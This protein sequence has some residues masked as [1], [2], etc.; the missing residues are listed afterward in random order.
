[1]IKSVIFGT[2]L[3]PVLATAGGVKDTLIQHEEAIEIHIATYEDFWMGEISDS[4][5]TPA[6]PEQ[7]LAITSQVQFVD[8]ANDRIYVRACTTQFKVTQGRAEVT[9]V[10]CQSPY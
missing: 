2:L 1:M 7:D 4:K 6:P 9:Q 10:T 3:F 8:K 5:Y